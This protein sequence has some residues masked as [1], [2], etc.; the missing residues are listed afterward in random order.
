MN[1]N[2]SDRL[3]HGREMFEQFVQLQRAYDQRAYVL[4]AD[5]AVVT[6]TRRNLLS[7]SWIGARFREIIGSSIDDAR[8]RRR[9]YDY[10]DVQFECDGEDVVVTAQFEP[11]TPGQS[12]VLLV[13][14]GIARCGEWRILELHDGVPANPTLRY[15][16]TGSD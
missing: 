3:Q 2:D 1:E 4:L 8:R 12:G 15:R 6:S 5:D 10:S 7:L 9:K 16:P 14:M 13:R 11:L